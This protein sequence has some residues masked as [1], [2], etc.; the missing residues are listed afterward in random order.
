MFLR[1]GRFERVFRRLGLAK[2]D[3]PVRG[4]WPGLAPEKIH[5]QRDTES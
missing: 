1:S 5:Q 2:S 3:K 4:D